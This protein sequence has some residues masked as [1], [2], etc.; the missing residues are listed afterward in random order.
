MEMDL[1][2]KCTRTPG[3][4][5]EVTGKQRSNN[6]L[7]LTPGPR[8]LAPKGARSFIVGPRAALRGVGPP[9]TC[10]SMR[11]NRRAILRPVLLMPVASFYPLVS[12]KIDC[13]TSRS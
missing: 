9:D 12:R 5:L 1:W 6:A 11:Q 2:H 7:M 13:A 10:H 3:G 8:R 4:R